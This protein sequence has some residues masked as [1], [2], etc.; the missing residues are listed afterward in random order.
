MG[1]S[2]AAKGGRRWRYYISRATLTGRKLDAGSVTRVPAAQIEK[3]VFDA[4]KS[5][6]ATGRSREGF[7][8]LPHF[9]ASGKTAVSHHTVSNPC[10]GIPDHEGMLGAIERVTI[11]AKAIEI[12]LSDSVVV[13]GQ[14]R[15]LTVPWIPPSPYQRRE[16]IQGEDEPRAPIRPMRTRARAVFVES[17]R[18]AHRWLNELITDP[19]QT[20]EAIAGRE[21]RSERSIRMTLSLAFVAPPIVAAA[22]EG[23]LPRGFG[24][25][26]LMDLPMVWSHQWKALG[27]KAP[28]QV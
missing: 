28:A 11:G 27:L 3:Q 12:Q 4:I 19:D 21:R 6:I 13:D 26:R 1:P 8:A 10:Q 18:N 15:T 2:H 7:G 16:I 24:T 14:D 25:K 5:A 9:P 17:L 23:R 20:I 22:I